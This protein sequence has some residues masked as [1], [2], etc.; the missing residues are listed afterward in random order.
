MLVRNPALRCASLQHLD[1]T[2][3]ALPNPLLTQPKKQETEEDQSQLCFDV[4]TATTHAFSSH[5]PPLNDTYPVIK[6]A[7]DAFYVGVR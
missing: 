2:F 5:P 3:S 7:S 1:N 4:R 6:D